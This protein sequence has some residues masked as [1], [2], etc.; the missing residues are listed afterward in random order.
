MRAPSTGDTLSGIQLDEFNGIFFF[1]FF[2]F[3]FFIS[4]KTLTNLWYYERGSKLVVIR[5]HSTRLIRE[6]VR[7]LRTFDLG[8]EDGKHMGVLHIKWVSSAGDENHREYLSD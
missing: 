8:P 6:I 1:F 3:F 5:L 2:F 7:L 4:T